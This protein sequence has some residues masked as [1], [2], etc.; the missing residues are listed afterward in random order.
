MTNY[1]LNWQNSYE[2]IMINDRLD[3]QLRIKA[4]N[5]IFLAD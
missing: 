1:S 5:T 2:F 4:S 3:V